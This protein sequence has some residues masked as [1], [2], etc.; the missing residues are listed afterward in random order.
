MKIC[1]KCQQE[2]SLS[3]FYKDKKSKD[4][5]SWSCAECMKK[6]ARKDYHDNRDKRRA[7]HSDWSKNNRDYRNRYKRKLYS[8]DRGK[9]LKYESDR[10]FREKNKEE[11]RQKKSEWYAKNKERLQNKMRENYREN[12]DGYK[13]RARQ[14]KNKLKSTVREH[15]TKTEIY[16]RDKGLCFRCSEWVD[17]SI[18]HPD[19]KCLSIHHLMP[20]SKGGHDTPDNVVTSHLECNLK[21]GVEVFD[22]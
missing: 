1:T 9:K 15:Y 20:L 13:E 2:K 10:R 14:R 19:P 21:Q 18:K 3:N 7:R 5:K 6:S 11:L 8:T 22:T 4:G 17:S 12:S 16:E